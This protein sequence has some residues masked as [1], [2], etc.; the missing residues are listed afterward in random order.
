MGKRPENRH[1]KDIVDKKEC[2]ERFFSTSHQEK[3]YL[4][5][6]KPHD[7]P[8]QLTHLSKWSR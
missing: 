4:K 3:A 6:N 8:V 1:Q 5:H 2:G 7:T